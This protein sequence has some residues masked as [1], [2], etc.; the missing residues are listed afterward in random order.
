M[1]KNFCFLVQHFQEITGK[2]IQLQI[3][4]YCDVRIKGEF[5]IKSPITCFQDTR[6]RGNIKEAILLGNSI[7]REVPGENAYNEFT[8][9]FKKQAINIIANVLE[10]RNYLYLWV[11]A[12]HKVV[13]YTNFLIPILSSQVLRQAKSDFAEIEKSFSRREESYGKLS[14][15]LFPAWSLSYGDIQY[16]DDSYLWT[17]IKNYYY[18]DVKDEAPWAE[19]CEEIL[20]R[21]YK[22]S[23]YKSLAEFD[24]LFESFTDT[25]KQAI[26]D[27]LCRNIGKDMPNIL[28]EGEFLAGY[29][30]KD[31][32]EKLK[33]YGDFP[34]VT[35]IIFVDTGYKAKL[36]DI[37]ETFI[38]MEPG[39]IASI[40]EIPL[41]A[42]RVTQSNSYSRYFYLYFDTSTKD[43]VERKREAK[44]LKK[45]IKSFF[46]N[47][48]S[49][50][51][52]EG[53][54]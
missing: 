26:L 5:T 34:N 43:S 11:Y 30:K 21:K 2:A 38:E 50:S 46:E 15:L 4:G 45:A 41:L 13:Y 54:E 39:N 32:V 10:A 33:Q 36:L 3:N 24:L 1:D 51:V 23:L 35:N 16:L 28:E 52:I 44:E 49:S 12:H 19:L 17:G 48:V 40:S 20:S 47:E 42:E 18:R 25:Q 8:V 22:A 37:G 7:E 29:L 31:F 9:G 14:E 27:Y 53:E 6:V